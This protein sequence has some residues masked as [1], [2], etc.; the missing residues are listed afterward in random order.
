M[1][2]Q[3]ADLQ[4]L[5]LDEL[6]RAVAPAG[7]NVPAVMT[8]L[9]DRLPTIWALYA[10]KRRVAL[11]QYH[12]AV[13]HAVRFLM[14]QNWA[15]FDFA[16]EDVSEKRSQILSNLKELLDAA[17][18]EIAKLEALSRSNRG[19]K[20]GRLATAAPLPLSE[21]ETPSTVFDPNSPVY[22]GDAR[23]RIR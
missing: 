2:L 6:G 20:V 19:P 13:K 21:A 22:G 16:D 12:Y 14:G 18:A 3:D 15:Q 5:I 9:E 23:Q 8:A 17:E 10:S 7:S 1:A 11:L 4:E